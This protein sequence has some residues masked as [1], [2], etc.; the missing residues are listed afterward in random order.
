MKAQEVHKARIR[1]LG[2]C[3]SLLLT[4]V[5]VSAQPQFSVFPT[6]DIYADSA[7]FYLNYFE[8][9][10]AQLLGTE[11]DTSVTLYLAATEDEFL[12]DTGTTPPD[13]GAGIA[14]LE[15]AKIVIKSPKYMPVNK[16]FR[17]LIGHELTHV[18]LH[19]AAGGE[20]IPRWLHE[21]LA[22]YV[23]GE[24]HIGQDL[25][26]ARAA[27][28]G[29]I[30]PLHQLESLSTFRGVQANLAYTES[31]LAVSNLLRTTDPFLLPD[32]LEMYRGSA[33]FYLSWKTTMG[34]D[35]VSWISR[36]QND[37]SRQYHFFIFLIDDELFWILLAVIFILLFI[38][39]KAQNARTRK[40]WKR[41]E[42]I[43][44]PD[45]SYKKY[46]DGY[47]DEENKV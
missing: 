16:S 22:M 47:Y 11:L 23:S 32:F 10:L 43:S 15:Q 7:R 35:Y 39:K 41:E 28:T 40:R 34:M 45:D 4:C 24:W 26:V 19:R 25:L 44:P 42:M 36:W 17:E 12:R 18:M 6:D 27:W 13:W 3:L 14:I 38:I 21:G 9:K 1:L 31:Y 5:T 33:D 8:R 30:I 20:W 2:F 46:Y 37:T 29:N